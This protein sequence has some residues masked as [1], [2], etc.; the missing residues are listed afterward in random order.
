MERL[1][2]RREFK[3]LSQ[4]ALGEAVGVTQAAISGFETGE[5]TPRVQTLQK[6]AN[7]L[8][9]TVNDLLDDKPYNTA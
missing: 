1:K 7:E 2:R 9:C 3:G 4:Q 6:L 8:D 5:K